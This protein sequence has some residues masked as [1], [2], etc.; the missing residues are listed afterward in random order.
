MGM[1]SANQPDFAALA[2]KSGSCGHFDLQTFGDFFH[3]FCSQ[4]PLAILF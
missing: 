2:A 4:L 3:H 1:W